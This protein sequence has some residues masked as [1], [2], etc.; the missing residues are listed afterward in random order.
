MSAELFKD[1]A[2]RIGAKICQEAI[3]HEGMCT[4]IGLEINASSAEMVC[5]RAVGPTVY[6]GTAGIAYFL[7][8]LFAVTQDPVFKRTALGAVRHSTRGLERLWREQ[9]FG[10]FDGACGVLWSNALTAAIVDGDDSFSPLTSRGLDLWASSQKAS[11]SLD[12]ISGEAGIAL[13]LLSKSTDDGVD[14]ITHTVLPGLANHLMGGSLSSA[15][16]AGLAHGAAGL[17]TALSLLGSRLRCDRYTMRAVEWAC[18]LLQLFDKGRGNWPDI[19]ATPGSGTHLPSAVGWCH[20][21]PGILLMTS[22]IPDIAHR[23]TLTSQALQATSEQARLFVSD[24][25]QDVTL[26]HGSL[27]YALCLHLHGLRVNCDE[28]VQLAVRVAKAACRQKESVGVWPNA[29]SKV[30][31]SPQLMTGTA[32]VGHALLQIAGCSSMPCILDPIQLAGA[33]GHNGEP[34]KVRAR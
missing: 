14:A 18:Y 24:P 30:E 8:D 32:G 16:L 34:P 31:D 22:V 17:C 4:W 15:P 21:A 33:V 25:E 11:Q 6:G 13:T 29:V 20:G 3:W 23:A 19:R 26:C 7:A 1:Q 28:H 10:L 5:S 12:I 27:G 9:Y 2:V